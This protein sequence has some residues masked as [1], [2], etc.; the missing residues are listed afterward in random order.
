VPL[1]T[2]YFTDTHNHRVLKI[3]PDGLLLV[4]AGTGTEGDSGD[5][6]PAI[7]ARLDKPL[8]LALDDF[9]SLYIADWGNHRVRCVTP[10]GGISTVA[11]TGR[12]GSTADGGPAVSARLCHP[13]GLTLD[14]SAALYVA[15]WA[16]HRVRRLS[17][18]ARTPE[19]PR[20]AEPVSGSVSA[21]VVRRGL[22]FQ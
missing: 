21:G 13:A 5:G 14:R 18:A 1:G 7:A 3:T 9:G 8:G 16:G 19:Q 22:P 10:D 11:G 20:A 17:P 15:D 4:V 12:S 6:R 2:L